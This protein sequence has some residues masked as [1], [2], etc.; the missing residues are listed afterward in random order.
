V[1][2]GTDIVDPFSI[3]IVALMYALVAPV[4]VHW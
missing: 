4:F 3:H 1:G 2:T